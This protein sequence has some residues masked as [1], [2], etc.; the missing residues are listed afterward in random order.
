MFGVHA[1]APIENLARALCP[2]SECG[3][4][5]LLRAARRRKNAPD[6]HRRSKSWSFRRRSKE[7]DIDYQDKEFD[8][9][10]DA[11]GFEE[12]ERNDDSGKVTSWKKC[13]VSSA[14]CVLSAVEDSL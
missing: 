13:F 7:R 11:G 3:P 8:L 12:W 2:C 14:S 10:F 6:Q 5:L 4:L 9:D 1:T